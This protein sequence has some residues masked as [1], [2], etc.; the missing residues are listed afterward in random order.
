MSY[1]FSFSESMWSYPTFTQV[2]RMSLRGSSSNDDV[3][4]FFFF[5]SKTQWALRLDFRAL[6]LHTSPPSTLPWPPTQGR[7]SPPKETPS[8]WY[9]R[10]GACWLARADFCILRNLASRLLKH[11]HYQ[12]LRDVNL[13]WNKILGNTKAVLP[14]R[15]T[16]VWL[17][18]MLVELGLRYLPGQRAA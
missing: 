13:Q 1:M 7:V 16:N 9:G 8:Q 6:W 3:I 10:T 11:S 18:P 12:K 14:Y 17:L 15:F 4:F 2:E 5:F